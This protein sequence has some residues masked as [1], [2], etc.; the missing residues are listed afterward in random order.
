MSYLCKNFYTAVLVNSLTKITEYLTE[1]TFAVFFKYVIFGPKSIT[2]L[3]GSIH[4]EKNK[5]YFPEA[6]FFV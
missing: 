2:G 1:I 6:F 5:N 3:T 4:V